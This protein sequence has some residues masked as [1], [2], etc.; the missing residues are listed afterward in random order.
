MSAS[1]HTSLPL[2]LLHLLILIA[3]VVFAWAAYITFENKEALLTCLF[4]TLA[5]LFN[6]LVKVYLSKEIWAVIDACSAIF[7]LIVSPK[8]R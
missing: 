6:P 8:L 3:C 1:R 5:L 7:L 4:I 2:W